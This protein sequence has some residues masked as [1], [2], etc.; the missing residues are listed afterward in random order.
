MVLSISQISQHSLQAP[1][2]TPSLIQVQQ[3]VEITQVSVEDVQPEG[4]EAIAPEMIRLF[5]LFP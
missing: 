5:R 1:Q 4:E 3:L 2:L